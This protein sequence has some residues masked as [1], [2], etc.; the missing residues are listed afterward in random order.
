ME[1]NQS[2]IDI[3]D[4]ARIPKEPRITKSIAKFKHIHS[5]QPIYHNE[6]LKV[7]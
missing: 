4:L 1:I 7:Q 3:Y 5:A 2:E 6:E